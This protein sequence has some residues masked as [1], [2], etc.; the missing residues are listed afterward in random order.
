M[1]NQGWYNPGELKTVRYDNYGRPSVVEGSRV[2]PNT[3]CHIPLSV[4]ADFTEKKGLPIKSGSLKSLYTIPSTLKPVKDRI[5]DYVFNNGKP[6]NFESKADRAL[7]KP[8]RRNY[9]HF[10]AQYG[11][12]TSG[13]RR[14]FWSRKRFRKIVAG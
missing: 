13:A 5:D 4:M 8:L 7:L 10:S 9:L 1:V 2:L 12:L 6:L 11:S 14:K 3:Y